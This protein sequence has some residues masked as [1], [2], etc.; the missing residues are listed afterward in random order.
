MPKSYLVTG[1][2]GFIG[3]HICDA[4]LR[5]GQRVAV[6]DNFRSGKR[7]NL[8]RASGD[9]TI[10][11]GDVRELDGF[12]GRIGQVDAVVHLAALISGYDSL[13]APDEYVDV[14]V[15]GLLRVIE[16]A[17][18]RGVPRIVFAS[19]STVYGNQAGVPL[20]ETTAPEPLTVYA[21]T[22]LAGEH[23]LRLYGAMHGLTHCSLRL[24]NVYGPRQAPDHPYANVTCKFSHA[25]AH[26]LPVNLY[27]DGEQS[28][29]FVYAADVVRAFMAV[30]DQSDA[31]IYNVGTGH[32]ARINQLIDELEQIGGRAL[33]VK[34]QAPWP[35]DIR[36]IRASIDRFAA[37]FGFRPEVPLSEG[38]RR[39]VEFF[40]EEAA[41]A[42]G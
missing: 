39:T 34:R 22:K 37:E 20:T 10:I 1:G 42:D 40:Q 16:F 11:E 32:T 29:D 25:A 21:L 27:G 2:A 7:S 14:N 9:L 3:S 30:L 13:S 31:S 41:S 18:A 35:N 33:E 24:F 36:S 4:L 28:R 12:A 19:S 26:G 15:R 8:P 23:L 6:L 38:L 5:D 17:T